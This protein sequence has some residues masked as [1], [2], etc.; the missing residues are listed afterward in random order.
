MMGRTTRSAT[1][2]SVH[3]SMPEPMPVFSMTATS[4]SSWQFPAPAPAPARHASASVAPSWKATI[5]FATASDRFWCAWMPASASPPNSASMAAIL[6]FTSSIV[7][8]PAE[9]MM[10]T[11]VAPASTMILP[12]RAMVSGVVMC[13]II[14]SPCTSIPRSRDSPMCWMAMSAS[15]QWVAIRT[16]SAPS[17]AARSSCSL[18]PM[19]GWNVTASR[20]RLITR[21]AAVSSSSSLCSERMY[22]IE[23]A[24][25]PSPCPT[26][27]E[28]TPAS[29]SLPAIIAT[30]S[31][32]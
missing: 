23:E 18:V 24:P 26:P 15:V 14:R 13:G 22:W 16:R 12:C 2:S 25:R 17:P 8:A 1:S 32:V 19:P 6:A 20:A 4:A 28:C 29:S 31:G 9:S 3:R 27:M 5:V 21:R 30:C 11:P 10:C 7:S